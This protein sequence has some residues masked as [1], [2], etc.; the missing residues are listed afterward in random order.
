[1]SRFTK[2][3]YLSDLPINGKVRLQD[4]TALDNSLVPIEITGSRVI[5]TLAEHAINT[6]KETGTPTAI[7]A[8]SEPDEAQC[9]WDDLTSIGEPLRVVERMI[10]VTVTAYSEFDLLL[11][12]TAVNKYTLEQYQTKDL[13]LTL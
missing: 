6:V 8:C 10:A 13:R 2:E 11:S 3:I 4:S 9:H 5:R 7:V 12:F 1:M